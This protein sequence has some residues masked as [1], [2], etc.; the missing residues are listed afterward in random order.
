MVTIP[1]EFSYY[2]TNQEY[3]NLEKTCNPICMSSLSINV[4]QVLI[5]LLIDHE[6][7]SFTTR[8]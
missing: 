3:Q 4:F 8:S 2:F 5:D 6:H 7:M 1:P